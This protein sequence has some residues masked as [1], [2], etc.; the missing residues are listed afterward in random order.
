MKKAFALVVVMAM[1]GCSEQT[2]EQKPLPIKSVKVMTVDSNN[3]ASQRT[4]SGSLASSNV[5][6]V[7]FRV[8]GLVNGLFVDTGERVEMGQTLATLDKKEYELRLQ[9]ARAELASARALRSEKSEDLQRQKT[10]KSKGFVAQSAVDKAQAAFNTANSQLDVAVNNLKQ[11]ENNLSYSTLT[12]PMSGE[13][14]SRAVEPFAEVRAG[15][16]ILELQTSNELEANVLI[17][18]HLITSVDYGDVVSVSFPSVEALS[19]RAT[20]NE[21][22]AQSQSSSGFP[23]AV[24]LLDPPASLKPGLTANVTFNLGE[25]TG[26]DIFLVP[27][28]SLDTRLSAEKPSSDKAPVFVVENGVATK[29]LVTI[30]DIRGNN[31]E[32]VEGL[33]QG[34]QLIVAGVAFIRPGEPVKIWEPNLNL[35]AVINY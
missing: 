13:V 25:N 12:S 27:I 16:T 18:D 22:G 21:I 1:A 10:L 8:S 15:Q 20:V 5:S 23:V 6:Q 24:E 29:R 14:V 32:I 31:V 2:N 9:S 19:L 17:P 3:L 28:S 35:P 34:D 33:K 7:S 4:F 11:A 26:S 30:R